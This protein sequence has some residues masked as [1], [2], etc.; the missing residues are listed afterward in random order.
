MGSGRTTTERGERTGKIYVIYRQ[1][2]HFAY[3]KVYMGVCV[4][5]VCVGDLE[6]TKSVN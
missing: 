1:W 3:Y 2:P 6:H 4:C 5:A